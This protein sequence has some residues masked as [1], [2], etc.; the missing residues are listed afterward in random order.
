[1]SVLVGCDGKRSE[2]MDWKKRVFGAIERRKDALSTLKDL[3]KGAPVF[4]YVVEGEE[5]FDP[6]FS[7]K[8][9]C[10]TIKKGLDAVYARL[11]VGTNQC[12][13]F[14]YR[15]RAVV[16]LPEGL[17]DVAREVGGSVYEDQERAPAGKILFSFR[18]PAEYLQKKYGINWTF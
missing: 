12:T 3:I 6:D 2:L 16:A 7:E 14:K 15:V 10:S 8:E 18:I 17:K 13:K 9:T 5:G 11:S 4:F 1:M